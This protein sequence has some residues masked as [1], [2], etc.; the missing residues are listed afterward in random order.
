MATVGS[1]YLSNSVF[2]FSSSHLK[3]SQHYPEQKE[4]KVD[5][6]MKVINNYSSMSDYMVVMFFFRGEE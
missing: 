3:L 5:L 6:L 2:W 1:L 4:E